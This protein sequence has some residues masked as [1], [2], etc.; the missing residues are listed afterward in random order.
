MENFKL[1]QEP[2]YDNEYWE[3]FFEEMQLKQAEEN[4]YV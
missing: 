2:D 1:T 4:E 3:E